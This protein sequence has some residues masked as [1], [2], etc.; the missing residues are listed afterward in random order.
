M[1]EI[2]KLRLQGLSAYKIAKE[3]HMD[4]P[5]VYTSLSS[6][7]QNFAAV[8]K[9]LGELKA[10]GW[11]ERLLEVEQQIRSE[12]PWQRRAVAAPKDDDV[13]FKMG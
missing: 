9:M 13:P 11:P 1:H 10:L 3:L 4:P 8:D 6:A 2:L 12:S 7:K 5:T